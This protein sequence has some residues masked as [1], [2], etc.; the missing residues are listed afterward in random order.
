MKSDTTKPIMNAKNPIAAEHP[1][2]GRMKTL[3]QVGDY[4]LAHTIKPREMAKS[5]ITISSVRRLKRQG[6]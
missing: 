4:L 2:R 3:S 5:V 1:I 6:F